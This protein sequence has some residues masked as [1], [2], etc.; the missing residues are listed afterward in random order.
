LIALRLDLASRHRALASG[1]ATASG[2]HGG[3]GSEAGVAMIAGPCLPPTRANPPGRRR[4]SRLGSKSV[5]EKEAEN[6][7]AIAIRIEDASA[8]TCQSEAA[9]IVPIRPHAGSVKA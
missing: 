8:P 3:T 1:S 2:T 9:A 6:P 5:P 4:L 7:S